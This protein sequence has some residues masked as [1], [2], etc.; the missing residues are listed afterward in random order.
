MND[1]KIF[2]T[3]SLLFLIIDCILVQSIDWQSNGWAYGC[4]FKNNNLINVKTISSLCGFE[5]GS[6]PGCTHFTW[7]PFEG[8]I[9]LKF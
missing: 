4:D 2:T 7:T 3:F 1:S 5:C 9:Y 8:E 6:T